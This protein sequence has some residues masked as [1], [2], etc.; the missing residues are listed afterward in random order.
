M[1][2]IIDTTFEQELR[3][4]IGEW[5]DI[6]IFKSCGLSSKGMEETTRST[7]S[8]SINFFVIRTK[9]CNICKKLVA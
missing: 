5:I 2:M 4:D 9:T 8:S 1:I 3:M 7:S 6:I